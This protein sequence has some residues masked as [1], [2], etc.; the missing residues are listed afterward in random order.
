MV[1]NVVAGHK[2]LYARLSSA[3]HGNLRQRRFHSMMH[4]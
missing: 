1:L 3:M 4:G 2:R